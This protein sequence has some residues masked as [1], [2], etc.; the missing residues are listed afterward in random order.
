MNIIGNSCA[1]SYVVRDLIKEQFSNPFVWC[2][3]TE[4]DIIYVIYNYDNIN[5]NDFKIELYENKTFHVKNVKVIVNGKIEIKYPHYCLSKT[6][7]KVDGINV[8]SKD[9]VNWVSSK[10]LERVN[11]MKLAGR[12]FYI[13]GGT[14]KDQMMSLSTKQLFAECGNVHILLA[15]DIVHDNYK[16]AVT[17]FNKIQEHLSKFV[18]SSITH[19]S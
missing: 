15:N 18:E 4:A 7:T 17:N 6:D 2:S 1:S 14:W 9:I 3:V 19:A 10:Y 8:F 13:L 12:P 5:W 16:V 11:R